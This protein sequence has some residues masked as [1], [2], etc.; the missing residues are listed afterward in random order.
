M[1]R[2]SGFN[3]RRCQLALP[4]V[5]AGAMLA[6]DVT[7]QSNSLEEIVVTARKREESLLSVPISITAINEIELERQNITAM[8]DL[9]QWTPALQ[10]QDV[11]GTFQNPVIRGLAQTDQISPVGNVGVFL[12]GVPLSNRSGL[13]FGALDVSR[14]EVIKGPQSALYGRN[15]FAGAINYVTKGPV[16]GQVEGRVEATAGTRGR[17]GFQGNVN[18]PMG[19]TLALRVF[20]GFSE[21]DGTI[22]NLRDGELLG[23]WDTRD[24][25]GASLLWEPREGTRVTLFGMHSKVDMNGPAIDFSNVTNNN[26]GSPTFNLTGDPRFTLFCGELE[27]RGTV[28]RSEGSQGNKGDSTLFYLKA[29]HEF[30]FA[31]ATFLASSFESEYRIAVD[32]STVPNAINIPLFIPGLSVQS[33]LDSSTPRGDAKSYEL[34]LAS[35]GDE[36][37]SWSIGAFGFDSKDVDTLSIFFLPLGDPNGEPVLFFARDRFVATEEKAIFGSLGYAFTDQLSGTLELR[38]AQEDLRL[39]NSDGESLDFDN[40]TPRVTLDYAVNDDLLIFG[41]IGKGVKAGSFNVNVA[42]DS[43]GRT[44]DEETNVSYE[45]GAKAT[46]MDGRLVTTGAIWYTDWDDVQVQTAIENSPVSAVQNFGSAT[47]TGI[48]LEASFAA[49]D[50][51]TLRGTLAVLDPEYGDDFIDGE[52]LAP[53]GEFVGTTITNPGCT[54]AVGGNQISR[55]SDFQASLAGTYTMPSLFRD[56]DGYISAGFSHESGKFSTGL[57]ANDQGDINLANLRLGLANDKFDV[58]LWV[59]NLLDEEWA[60][61]VTTT[62]DT[63]EGA[64]ATGVVRYRIYPGELRTVGIDV[65][66]NF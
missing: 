56:F 60:R 42:P 66:Y 13:E 50:N 47:S 37:L 41:S 17:L 65:R 53:C 22:R 20:G 59:D 18:I 4:F 34:R 7:A 61:R 48:E 51:L 62:P 36:R 24:A 29:E 19:D 38:Y 32:T 1:R 46:F 16:L 14:I 6:G 23:G 44:F 35:N 52:L 55:T 64:P 30:D 26:C 27:P 8:E 10:F 21:F 31:T 15:T 49:T 54:A 43:S 25:Y 2:S 40:V 57:N 11:N 45:L 12:D 58:S 33:L 3:K 9:A 39:I 28:D 5:A 63:A